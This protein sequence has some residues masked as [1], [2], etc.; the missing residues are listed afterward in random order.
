VRL[1]EDPADDYVDK[2]GKSRARFGFTGPLSQLAELERA[3]TILAEDSSEEKLIS[4]D[5]AMK[6]KPDKHGII[7]VSAE[8]RPV[9]SK[10]VVSFG[11]YR[12]MFDN[13]PYPA[14]PTRGKKQEQGTYKALTITK[15]KSEQTKAKSKNDD[16]FFVV[17]IPARQVYKVL[18]AVRMLMAMNNI[19]RI[20]PTGCD[21]KSEEKVKRGKA[22]KMVKSKEAVSDSELS[23]DTEECM[24]GG[25]C[26]TNCPAVQQEE[27]SDSDDELGDEEEDEDE[28]TPT[29]EEEEAEAA[30]DPT[31]SDEEFID[32][33]DSSSEEDE[34]E[35]EMREDE[36]EDQ[37]DSE[38][39]PV[40]EVKRRKRKYEVVDTP[41]ASSPL[42]K[43]I[44]LKAESK[45]PSSS[46]SSASSTKRRSSSV[47]KRSS[48]KK[49]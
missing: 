6:I 1:G 22:K 20:V 38:E 27:D 29:L 47:S 11:A 2:Q 14:P 43:K 45:R 19:K 46:K 32:D 28:P 17:Q 18:R 4:F 10:K 24:C 31:T 26:K 23:D 13:A 44:K 3:L 42:K 12:V 49:R 8:C 34:Y 21:T 40:Q 30:E 9:Y 39:E 25:D 15:K 48:K 37:S 36:V 5:E 41:T 16:D 33:E 35:I 7:D